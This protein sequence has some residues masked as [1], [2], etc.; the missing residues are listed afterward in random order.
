[1]DQY[2]SFFLFFVSGCIGSLLF[3]FF[4]LALFAIYPFD[5]Q[6]A[7]VTWTI[8]YLVSILWQHSIHRILVFGSGGHYWRTLML[9]YLSYSTSIIL[10]HFFMMALESLGFDYKISWA[11]NLGITGI[12]NYFLVS[13]AF[14]SG[15]PS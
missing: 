9:T 2:Y 3:Y 6:K 12:F 13:A 15:K 10:G 5:V 8:S 7:S 1:M 14:S 4:Y 11:L